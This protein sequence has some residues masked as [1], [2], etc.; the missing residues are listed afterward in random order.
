MMKVINSLDLA[1]FNFNSNFFLSIFFFSNDQKILAIESK[2]KIQLKIFWTWCQILIFQSWKFVPN[3][4][5]NF[6]NPTFWTF[7]QNFH[8]AWSDFFVESVKIQ[9]QPQ[10]P[11]HMCHISDFGRETVKTTLYAYVLWVFFFLKKNTWDLSDWLFSK[12]KNFK[13]AN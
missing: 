11:S 6:Q 10:N 8:S 3:I 5:Q 9:H 13:I 1:F 4:F 12:K 7:S 2:K